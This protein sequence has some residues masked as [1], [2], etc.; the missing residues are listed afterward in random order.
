METIAAGQI[1]ADHIGVSIESK[2]NGNESSPFEITGGGL[3][4][5]ESK[6]NGNA[7]TKVTIS[8]KHK[9]FQSN[10]RGMETAILCGRFA[11][12]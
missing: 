7:G 2:R 11:L 1:L 3:V 5:I 6:R 10:L 4:S 9:G 8:W 12:G